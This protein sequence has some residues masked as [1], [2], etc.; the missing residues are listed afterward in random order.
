MDI[1]EIIRIAEP[2]GMKFI[3]FRERDSLKTL[4]PDGVFLDHGAKVETTFR[5]GLKGGLHFLFD[6]SHPA[7]ICSLHFDGYEHH[8]RHIDEAR[9]VGR[10]AQGLRPYCTIAGG[11]IVDDR[12]SDHRH[13][14]DRH[15]D[16]C[17]FLQLTDLL[18]GSFRSVLANCKNDAQANVAH[19]VA[20]LVEKWKQGAARMKNSRWHRAYCI[21]E[22]YLENGEW[23][24]ADLPAKR[25]D[26]QT[27]FGFPDSTP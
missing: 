24:F 27:S 23:H 19:P 1:R 2:L 5:M 25:N 11:D 6:E 22:C 8:K 3:V 7:T 16:D 17:Q 12:P 4:D 15:Y 18:I 13:P 10:L 26:Q 9:I 20:G 14:N 21:S